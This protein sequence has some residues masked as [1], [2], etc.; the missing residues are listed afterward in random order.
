MSIRYIVCF[1][2]LVF[3][4]ILFQSSAQGQTIFGSLEG[5]VVEKSTKHPL[6]YVNVVIEGTE[7]GAATDTAGVFRIFLIPVGTY[8]IQF[9]LIG[10]QP[11]IKNN[12]DIRPQRARF[13]YVE[14]TESALLGEGITVTPTY[15]EK[16]KDAA[17]STRT[18]DFEDIRQ[19][20]GSAEDVQ[21]AMQALP[22]VVSGSDQQNE[23]ITRGGIPGENLF[24]MDNI[25]IPNPNHF[26]F[27]GESGGPINVLNTYMIRQIDFYTGAF[28]ARYG[29]KVSSVLDISLREG[30]RDRMEGNGY[31]GMAGAGILLEGPIQK[32]RGSWIVS[33][34]KSFLDLIISSTGLTSV[35]KYYNV[36]GKAVYDVSQRNKL[37]VNALYGDDRI[38]IEAEDEGGIY[39]SGDENVKS[40]GF[41]YVAGAALRTLW[42][43]RLFSDLTFYQTESNWNVKVW[44]R[45]EAPKFVNDSREIIR[46][47]KGDVLFRLSDNWEFEGGVTMKTPQFSHNI[48]A[49][50]DTIFSWNPEVSPPE[51]TG[52]FRAYPP[53]IISRQVSTS[54]TGGFIQSKTH[55]LRRFT[56]TAGLRY[57]RFAYTDRGYVSPRLGLTAAFNDRSALHLAYGN[58][59]QSPSY[60]NLTSHDNNSHLKHKTTEHFIAGLEFLIAEDQKATLEVY[61]K[62]YRDVPV[63]LSWTTPDPF[64]RDQGELVPKGQG[65]A[66][67]VEFFLQKKL[68]GSLQYT[69]SYAYSVSKALDLRTDKYYNWD[70]DYRHV[71]TFIGGYKWKLNRTPWYERFKKKKLYKAFSWIL[72]FADEVIFSMRLRY[73]GG[74]PYTTP[75]YYPNLRRWVT[76]ESL[77]IN[78]SRYPA[79]HRLDLRLDRRF[80]FKRWNLVT[81]FD[82]MNIYNRDNIWE[83][84]YHNDGSIEKILQFKTF[85]VVGIAAEF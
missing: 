77:L 62:K 44:E 9:S 43:K 19:D 26:G 72:P 8:N 7:L 40:S 1:F 2:I 85:P 33:A 28:P 24:V 54:K 67:G 38:L 82:F 10:H 35:P 17:A 12:V 50:A 21:R 39:Q 27:Q 57:D 81:Y 70:Y 49:R 36:Q 61:H 42:S 73:L 4:A 66:R 74:R 55:F 68:S 69:I 80:Y 29:D 16:G 58:L 15:F 23:I 56:A 30:N 76:E 13:L 75:V 45:K 47:L 71:F 78:D 6:A 51:L 31:A 41:Q 52:I 14:L 53:W 34:R 65:Y 63:P 79:Y 83:Y 18:M 25:E 22:A 11:I 59:N 5:R 64:D 20:P 46:G 37:T 3:P 60:I 32:G 48:D 84:I